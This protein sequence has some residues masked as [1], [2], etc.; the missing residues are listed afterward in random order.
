[1]CVQHPKAVF[2]RNVSIDPSIDAFG[3][4]SEPISILK[5][6]LM[7]MLGV[8]VAIEINVLI[9]SVNTS[10]DAGIIIDAWCK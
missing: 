3:S 10:I 6:V 8:N 5:L 1:M 7:L 9:P 2:T 4:V